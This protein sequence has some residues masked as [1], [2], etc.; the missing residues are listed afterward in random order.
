M[1]HNYEFG[2]SGGTHRGPYGVPEGDE[3]RKHS[4]FSLIVMI[5]VVAVLAIAG[6]SIAFWALGFL[7]HLAGWILRIAVLAAVA[8][9]VWRWVNRRLSHDRV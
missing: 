9:F 8:A 7:F 3:P 5:V 4:M 6:L 2:S 1:M